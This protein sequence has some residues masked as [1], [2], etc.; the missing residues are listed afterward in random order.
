MSALES[1]VLAEYPTVPQL[2]ARGTQRGGEGPR[3][4]SR[5]GVSLWQTVV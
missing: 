4:E 3:E 2:P 5:T 1:D